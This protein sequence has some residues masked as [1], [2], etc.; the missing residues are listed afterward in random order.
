M[1]IMNELEWQ[2]LSYY[3]IYYD[4]FRN[5]M[6]WADKLALNNFNIENVLQNNNIKRG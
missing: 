1:V 3:V 2:M 4:K 5:V 6:K